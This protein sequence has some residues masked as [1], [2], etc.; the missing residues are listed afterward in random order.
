MVGN[1]NHSYLDRRVRWYYNSKIIILNSNLIK[2]KWRQG[3]VWNKRK[4]FN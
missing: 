1:I 4:T 2:T 3:K